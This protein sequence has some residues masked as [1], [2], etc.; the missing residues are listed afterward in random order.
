VTHNADAPEVLWRPERSRVA[1]TKI[2]AFRHWLR[3]ERDVEVDDYQ[4]LWEFSVDRAPE[5]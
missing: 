3:A 1:D 4:S 2:E 5:F